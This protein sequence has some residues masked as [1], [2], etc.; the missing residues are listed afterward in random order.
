MNV[1][2]TLH[3]LRVGDLEPYPDVQRLLQAKRWA[4]KTGTLEE[5]G[6]GAVLVCPN[7]KPGRYYV[8]DGQ[9]RRDALLR[10]MGPEAKVHA[11]VF[12]RMLSKQEAAKV[13]RQRNTG[14]AVSTGVAHDRGVMAGDPNSLFVQSILAQLPN[15][16]AIKP[17]YVMLERG[18]KPKVIQETVNWLIAIWGPKADYPGLFIAAAANIK[19][20]L[21]PSLRKALRD[22]TPSEW[23]GQART[24]R[25]QTVGA[26]AQLKDYVAQMLEGFVRRHVSR[27]HTS[28][29]K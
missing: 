11:E 8:I 4:R 26:R 6:I 10:E 21:S 16:R 13:F 27:S 29:A 22:R 23:V 20:G 17:F 3:D 28:K 2:T 14:I 18:I 12:S 15:T 1:T 19:Q 24:R 7:G 9:H 25:F 5:T